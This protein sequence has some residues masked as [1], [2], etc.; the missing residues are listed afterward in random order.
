MKNY[1][2]R[3]TGDCENCDFRSKMTENETASKHTVFINE[4]FLY[5]AI[6]DEKIIKIVIFDPN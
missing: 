6:F 2:A 4:T 5:L 1:F 3:K